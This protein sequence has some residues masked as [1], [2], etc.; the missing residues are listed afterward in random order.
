M[1]EN[2]SYTL[3]AQLTFCMKHVPPTQKTLNYV[4]SAFQSAGSD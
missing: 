3:K 4:F 2:F 1:N